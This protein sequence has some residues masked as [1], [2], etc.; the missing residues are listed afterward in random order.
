MS[1]RTCSPGGS[2]SIRGYRHRAALEYL[3]KAIAASPS[4]LVFPDEAGKMLPKHTALEHVLRRAGIVTGYVHKCRRQGCGHHEAAAD[5]NPRRCPKCKFKLFPVGEVRKIR[6]HHLRHTT[7]SLLLMQGA[8]LA[9]VQRIMR[10]QDPRITTEV[11]GHLAPGYLKN[12]INRL[13]FCPPPADLSASGAPA[14]AGA[15]PEAP[16]EQQ[17]QIAASGAQEPPPLAVV[18]DDARPA[19][20]FATR[21]LPNPRRLTRPLRAA[22]PL[23][24]IRA[25]LELSGREDLNLRPFGPE[26]GAGPSPR[27]HQQ[28]DPRSA[29]RSLG[30]HRSAQKGDAEKEA[31]VG[32]VV[33]SVDRSPPRCAL[34][35]AAHSQLLRGLDE[36][37]KRC[38]AL[39]TAWKVEEEAGNGSCVRFE[40]NLQPPRSKLLGHHR[41]EDVREPHAILRERDPQSAVIGHDAPAHRHSPVPAA[42]L[43]LPSVEGASG[44]SEGHAFVTEEVLWPLRCALTLEIARSTHDDKTQGVR[45]AHLHHV[46]LNRFAQAYA[47]VV[48]LGHDVDE[49]ILGDDFDIHSRMPGTKSW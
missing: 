30:V 27:A 25:D 1:S 35:C 31:S 4:E 13:S 49:T 42:P 18:R 2:G 37:T 36:E 20:P 8:D 23:E 7:A 24:R 26:S 21:L 41:L 33:V 14:G 15:T 32:R 43:E 16:T 47:R 6:F 46:A 11:Y 48:A 38:G 10:H 9:A 40:H 39:R 17:S 3:R 44:H 45:Q 28:L 22:E 29:G 34:L 12:E 5:A 19:A